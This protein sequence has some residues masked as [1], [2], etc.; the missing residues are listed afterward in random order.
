MMA[1]TERIREA[2]EISGN[3]KEGT[4]QRKARDSQAGVAFSQ[5]VANPCRKSETLPWGGGRGRPAPGHTYIYIY[6][7]ICI[8]TCIHASKHAQVHL[9]S[10]TY[11]CVGV[12]LDVPRIMISVHLPSPY[13]R[14]CTNVYVNTMWKNLLSTNHA[15]TLQHACF[16]KALQVLC[17]II[18]SVCALRMPV[19]MKC[20]THLY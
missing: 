9:C 6:I 4:Q 13:T 11:V 20:D 12:H 7:Y 19:F 10:H 1:Q 16:E 3:G 15:P 2:E 8:C 5:G 18:C 14:G 17:S